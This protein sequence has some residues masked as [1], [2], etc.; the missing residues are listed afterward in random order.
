MVEQRQGRRSD[1][2]IGRYFKQ[3]PVVTERAEFDWTLLRRRRS[4]ARGHRSGARAGHRDD[5]WRRRCEDGEVRKRCE[6]ARSLGRRR[7]GTA[8]TP[9]RALE[10]EP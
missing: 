4:I 8:R 10:L 5:K 2:L 1:R 7:T 3:R 9:R 6:V